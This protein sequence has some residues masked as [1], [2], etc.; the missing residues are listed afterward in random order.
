MDPVRRRFGDNLRDARKKVGISQE[1][2]STRAGLHRTAVSLHERGEREPR[3]LTVIKLA[4]GLG[5]EPNDLCEG[6]RWLPDPKRFKQFEA[7]D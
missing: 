1:E 3:I 7:E 6:I 4:H 5:I 2:L